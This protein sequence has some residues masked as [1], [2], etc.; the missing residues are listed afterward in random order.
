MMSQPASGPRQFSI[1]TLLL[2]TMLVAV[3]LGL[4]RMHPGLGAAALLFVVPALLRTLA[5]AERE[6]QHGNRLSAAEK[7]AVYFGSLAV[8]FLVYVTIAAIFIVGSYLS[9]AAGALLFNWH[10]PTGMIVGF[11]G[12]AATTVLAIIAAGGT[13]RWTWW[14]SRASFLEALHRADVSGDAHE[15]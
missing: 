2:V 15:S 3:C 6:K 5:L 8:T 9:V 4:F 14:P 13:V 12:Y 10:E 11:A 1:A 7:V